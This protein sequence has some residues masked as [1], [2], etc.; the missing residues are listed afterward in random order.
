M[1]PATHGLDPL[2]Q[3]SFL[4]LVASAH[5]DVRGVNRYYRAHSTQQ[6]LRLALYTSGIYEEGDTQPATVI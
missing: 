3:V 1:A 2:Q 5:R 6:S 4:T